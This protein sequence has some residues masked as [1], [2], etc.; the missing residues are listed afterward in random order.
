MSWVVL[1]DTFDWDLRGIDILG[2]A[3]IKKGAKLFAFPLK[4]ANLKYLKST[5]STAM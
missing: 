5:T 3:S 1:C 2:P 4:H